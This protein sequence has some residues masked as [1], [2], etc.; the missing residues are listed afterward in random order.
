MKAS[1]KITM[2]IGLVILIGMFMYFTF[3]AGMWAEFLQWI[4]DSAKE[5]K[6]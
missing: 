5:A 2:I 1:V 4:M 6:K 3:D